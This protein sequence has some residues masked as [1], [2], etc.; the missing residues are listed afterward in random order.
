MNPM[1]IFAHSLKYLLLLAVLHCAGAM[2]AQDA[3]ERFFG[4]LRDDPEVTSVIISSKMFGLFANMNSEDPDA[5]AAAEVLKQLKGIKMLSKSHADGLDSY[6]QYVRKIDKHYDVL[7][8]VDQADEKVGFYIEEQ[9]GKVREFVMIV[10]EPT[11]FFVMSI[12]GDIDLE[13]LSS[14]SKSVNVGGM[15]YLE[16]LEKKK[17]E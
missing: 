4:D 3:I 1:K 9:R 16:K 13:K 7:M 14:L 15:N 17:N 2:I 11:L 5:R 10:G 8:T 12:S 6:R